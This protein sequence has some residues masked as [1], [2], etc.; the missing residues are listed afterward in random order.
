VVET[1]FRPTGYEV[2]ELP[3]DGAGRT[4][5]DGLNLADLAGL[6]VGSPNFFGVVE[7]LGPMAAKVR[8]AGALFITSFTEPLAYGVFKNPGSLGADIACGEGQSLG[9]PRSFGGP[10]LGMFATLMKH[11]RNIPGRLVGRTHDLSGRR[12]FVL[13]LSTREQHIRREKAVS[14]ICTNN[15]L[16]A[17]AAA[18][19]MASAGSTGLA[20]L[21][22]QNRDK[23][24]YLKGRLAEKGLVSPFPGPTFNEFVVKMPQGFEARWKELLGQKIMAGLPIERYYPEL[25]GHYLFCA[26]EVHSRENL[27]QLAAE[28]T[29]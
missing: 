16:C 22:R 26:T 28:V 2:V 15:S 5:L 21:A 18:M 19:Y 12:G 14:N 3:F 10:G 11:I 24:E 9:L 27:D 29:K 23:A 8:D 13:T 25:A 7:D 4:V 17:L 1:Y 6:A 20:A